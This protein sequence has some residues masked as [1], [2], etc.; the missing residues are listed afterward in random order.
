MLS[1][2]KYTMKFANWFD[3]TWHGLETLAG[4]EQP[5]ESGAGE[6]R[7]DSRVTMVQERLLEALLLEATAT[8][9]I[10]KEA[11]T[12]APPSSS[13]TPHEAGP[14]KDGPAGSAT[15]RAEGEDCVGSAPTPMV[16]EG[17]GHEDEGD[18]HVADTGVDATPSG[19]HL[20]GSNGSGTGAVPTS[21][22]VVASMVDSALQVRSL[23]RK[24]YG[25]DQ[26]IQQ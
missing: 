21:V 1:I 10:T 14:D 12:Q 17:E 2:C 8:T 18:A 19:H 22:Q 24:S 20:A 3:R 26:N 16:V 15:V 13:P 23:P 4:P 5:G 25:D 11:P 9:N 7:Y 6:T